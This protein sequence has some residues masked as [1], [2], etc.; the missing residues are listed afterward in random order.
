MAMVCKSCLYIWSCGL[1]TS[2]FGHHKESV[3][4]LVVFLR[5][6]SGHEKS[7][8]LMDMLVLSGSSLS[9]DAEAHKCSHWCFRWRVPTVP[10]P[11]HNDGSP[12]AGLFL[13]RCRCTRWVLI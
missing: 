2:E 13:P 12:D 7:I 4:A 9:V 3:D 8:G 11:V 10:T 6:H 1:W 5:H